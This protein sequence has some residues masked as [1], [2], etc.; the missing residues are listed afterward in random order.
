MHHVST[1]FI[2]IPLSESAEIQVTPCVCRLPLMANQ[3][4]LLFER[5]LDGTWCRIRL[6]L[7]NSE[8]ERQL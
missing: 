8:E 1:F 3:T 2:P 6:D 4:S 7:S 5:K